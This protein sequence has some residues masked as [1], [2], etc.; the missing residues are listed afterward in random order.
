VRA[1]LSIALLILATLP[2]S[3]EVAPLRGKACWLAGS[4][5]AEDFTKVANPKPAT[6][7][8]RAKWESAASAFNTAHKSLAEFC[9]KHGLFEEAH[10]HTAITQPNP[11]KSS[12]R[13]NTAKAQD[14]RDYWKAAREKL[15]GVA[16][17]WTDY[18]NAAKDEGDNEQY[19]A[20]V[21]QALKTYL[22]CEGARRA[23][24]EA[25]VP[26]LGWLAE[27][28]AEALKKA[29][30]ENLEAPPGV[31]EFDKEFAKPGAGYVLRTK[32]FAVC[33]TAGFERTARLAATFDELYDCVARLLGETAALTDERI[34]VFLYG[35]SGEFAQANAAREGASWSGGF[36]RA[37]T[38]LA[39]FPLYGD[40]TLAANHELTHAI[41]DYA[42][43]GKPITAYDGPRGKQSKATFFCV[44][45]GIAM[46]FEGFKAG[47]KEQKLGALA[48]RENTLKAMA[49]E[50]RDL[51]RL[52]SQTAE[53]WAKDDA[54]TVRNYAAS[55]A[56]TEFC[57][58]AMAEKYRAC[59]LR[60]LRNHYARELEAKDFEGS[61]GAK[62]ADFE[63]DYYKW[64][65][66]L[67]K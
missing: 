13:A 37:R 14:Y 29:T 19:R 34:G 11:G 62:R 45:E 9:R 24:G 65:D 20:G 64:Y 49:K 36:Y 4:L 60:L 41:V 46:H 66:E 21:C 50:C 48:G 18:A 33:S 55:A 8:Q 6:A 22:D 43:R 51:E 58:N 31:A 53:S 32:H 44:A 47:A 28:R 61:F 10:Y 2:A 42:L 38:G 1:A 39:H 25:L 35:T 7:K 12:A 23:R 67:V 26:D 52:F 5:A 59:Y 63:A 57:V 40:S 16:T 56:F 15:A 17:K 30:R 54:D 3:A 27:D